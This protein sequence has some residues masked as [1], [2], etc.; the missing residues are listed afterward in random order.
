MLRQIRFLDL[1]TKKNLHCIAFSSRDS[2]RRGSDVRLGRQ[3]KAN[4]QWFNRFYGTLGKWNIMYHVPN[5][6]LVVHLE[7]SLYSSSNQY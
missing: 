4:L 5:Y 2:L 1:I 6:N 3:G 7:V